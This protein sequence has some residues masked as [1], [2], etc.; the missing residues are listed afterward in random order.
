MIAIAIV[1]GVVVL[2]LATIVFC[3][4]RARWR[5]RASAIAAATLAKSQPKD[6]PMTPTGP[7]PFAVNY[8]QFQGQKSGLPRSGS[9]IPPR[10]ISKG[11][12]GMG[13]TNMTAS[14]VPTTV[15]E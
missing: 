5:N 2:V 12:S 7:L 14:T 10:T 8:P 4:C 3:C 13:A 1:G 15:R 11:K 6:E 9:Y